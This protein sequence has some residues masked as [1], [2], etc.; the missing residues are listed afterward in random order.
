MLMIC[1]Y[2]SDLVINF[3]FLDM[4][5]DRGKRPIS[6]TAYARRAMVAE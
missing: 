6:A 3:V 5:C 4:E 2:F 1:C